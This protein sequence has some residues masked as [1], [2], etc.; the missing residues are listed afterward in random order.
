MEKMLRL[1]Y[2]EL[3]NEKL[4][5]PDES[6]TWKKEKDYGI[7]RNKEKLQ[8]LEFIANKYHLN[9]R[10]KLILIVEGD[11]ELEQIPRTIKALFGADISTFGI[12]IQNLKGIGNFEG[13]KTID[14]FGALEKFIDDYHCRQTVVFLILDNEGSANR[15]RERLL[16]R[17][18]QRYSKRKLTR[19]EYIQIWNKNIEYDNFNPKEIADALTKLCEH[20]YSFNYQKISSLVNKFG[21]QK[22]DDYYKENTSY[23]LPKKRLIELLFDIIIMNSEKELNCDKK[24]PII[25]QLKN[26]ISLANKNHQSTRLE[27]W[28]KNFESGFFGDIKEIQE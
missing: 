3:T 2:Q 17:Y 21:K 10:P 14:R 5:E 28:K 24:R 7:D 25:S 4:C 22:L 15:I 11:G 8:F 26:I 1:F 18:S 27:L 23:N 13:K 6:E 19:P 9:P 20:S 16:K 12:E